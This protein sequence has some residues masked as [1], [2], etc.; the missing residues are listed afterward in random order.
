MPAPSAEALVARAHDLARRGELEAAIAALS[1]VG[2]PSPGVYAT[3]ASL[4]R[5]CCDTDA[6]LRALDRAI[7]LGGGDALR[8]RRAILLPPVM[9]SPEEISADRQRISSGL[10]ALTARPLSIPDPLRQL[11]YL[12]FYLTYHGRD[13]LSIKRKLATVLRRACPSLAFTAPHCTPD[14]RPARR[15]RVGFVSSHLRDHTIGRLNAALVTGLQGFTG[16]QGLAGPS[17][18][19]VTVFFIGGP[20]DA[21]ARRIA[22]GASRAVSLPRDLAAARAEI[23]AARI[24]LLYFTDVGMDPMSGLLALSRLAPVQA[25]TWGHP[26]TTGSPE[27]DWFVAGERLVTDAEGFSER[28]A[29]L[30]DPTVCYARPTIGPPHRAPGGPT[31]LYLCP[32]TLFKLHPDFDAVLLAILRADPRGRILLMGGPPRWERK[33][34]ARMGH[35]ERVDFLPSVP[36]SAFLSLLA[37]ADVMLDPFPFGGG[38]TT[39]EAIAAGTP[40]VTLPTPLLRGR[41]TAALLEIVGAADCIAETPEDYVRLAV[42]LDRAAVSAR[43]SRGAHRVF[44]QRSAIEHHAVFFREAL[45]TRCV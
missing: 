13:D 1:R 20:A 19:D 18:F 36:R 43:I 15:P 14:W 3:L 7:A 27:V 44:D 40:V 37:S 10:D 5:E 24:D 32:Q 45:A 9:G 34:R 21:F 6:A 12:D 39:L 25:V 22:A 41:I 35:P 42:G 4:H 29:R 26:T 16:Q 28:L 17:G 33:I 8:L 30:P 23:A 2:T 38:N 31:R 11:P